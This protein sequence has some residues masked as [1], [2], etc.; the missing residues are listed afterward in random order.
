MLDSSRSRREQSGAALANSMQFLCKQSGVP[1]APL[2]L[3]AFT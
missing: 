3:K 2:A 1:F